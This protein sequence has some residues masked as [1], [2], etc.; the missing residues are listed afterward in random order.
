MRLVSKGVLRMRRLA[1]I[2]LIAGISKLNWTTAALPAESWLVLRSL[3]ASVP[4]GRR[5]CWVVRE[6]DGATY[7]DEIIEK[8]PSKLEAEGALA[9]LKSSG[10]CKPGYRRKCGSRPVQVR[11]TC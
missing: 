10:L 4:W 11:D 9:R 6:Q 3:D 7:S 1:A 2:T 8:Q 5:P